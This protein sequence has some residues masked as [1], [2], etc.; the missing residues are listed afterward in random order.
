MK[1]ISIGFVMLTIFISAVLGQTKPTIEWVSIPGGTFTMGSPTNEENRHD[2]ETQHQVTLNGFKISKYEITNAQYAAFLNAKKIDSD[3]LYAAG[4]FPTQVLIYASSWSLSYTNNRWIPVA[5]YENHPV[6]NV[7]WYGAKEFCTY[8]GGVLPTEEQWEY[9]CRA[10]T[11]TPFN[12]G[13]C[14]S[15][16]QANYNWAY[17]YDNCTNT[18]REYPGTTQ[19]VGSYPA[20]AFGLYNMHDNV[21][22]WCSNLFDA[23][24]QTN[25]TDDTSSSVRVF[26]GGS[27]NSLAQNCRSALRSDYDSNSYS[28][29]IG[30]RVV[31]P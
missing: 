15:N 10:N 13:V 25:S 20:N 1:K 2:D 8:V 6:I 5:G 27:W 4:A 31:I 9:A 17:P 14:L 7:T 22:E 11:S 21:S 18:N 12:T 19:A 16:T 26:R 28:D 29:F 3:G 24:A 23:T 30:F